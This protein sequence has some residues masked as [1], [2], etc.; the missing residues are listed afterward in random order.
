MGGM[1]MCGGQE[2]ILQPSKDVCVQV[3]LL[4]SPGCQRC[5]PND[6]CKPRHAQRHQQFMCAELCIPVHLESW[7][8]LL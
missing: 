4:T 6:A 5:H 2:A 3:S 1:G 7:S 8:V